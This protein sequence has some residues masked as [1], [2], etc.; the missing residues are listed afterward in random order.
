MTNR[1]DLRQSLKQHGVTDGGSTPTSSIEVLRDYESKQGDSDEIF[2]S[3]SFFILFGL[4]SV[5][6]EIVIRFWQDGSLA[7]MKINAEGEGV[8][9]TRAN[10]TANDLRKWVKN[11]KAKKWLICGLC[12]DEYNRI[13]SC[14]TAKEIWNTLQVDHEGTPQ[15]KRSRGTL[16]YSQYENFTMK[17]RET[18]QDMYTRFTTLTNEL[19]CLGR[20]I[21][22]EDKVEKILTRVL[23]ISW[24]RKITA[25]HES[26]NIAT[27]RLDELIRNLTAYE[28]R[29][30]TMNMDVP[31]KER[32]LALRITE[33]A[34]LEEDEM[35]MIT[36]DFK[37]YLM[38][39]KGSS[40][41]ENYNKARVP[42]KQ[43]NEGCYKC[44]KTDHHIK[45]FPQWKIEW[46]KERSERRNMKKEQVHP[47]K[48]KGST[49]AMVAAWGESSDEESDDEDGDEQALMKIGE[50][51]EESKVSII[52]L[53]DK[54]KF[55]SKE[56][57]SELLLDFIDEF[58]VINKEKEQLSKD[59][60]ILKVKCK[61]LELRV[62]ETVS[63]NT[64]LKNQVHTFEANILE[65]KSE[66]LKLK[67]GTSKKTADCTQLTLEENVGKLKDELYRKDE[68]VR[69]LKEDLGKVKHELDR[70]SKWNRSSDALSWLQEHYSSN[71]RGLG[72]GNQL[73]K[74]YPKS[75]YLTLPENKIC[76]HC[77]KTGHYKSECNAKERASQK[78]KNFVQGKNW[79]PS[80]SEGE[81]P[82]MVHGQWLL[83]ACDRKQGPGKRVNNIYIIDLSTLSE[84]ELTC[85]SVL[86]SD[87]LLWHKRLGHASLSQLN[88]LVSK[89]LVIGLPN[90]KFKE[91]KACE[92]CARGKQEHDDEAIELVKHLNETTAQ[93]EASLEEGTGD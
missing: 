49:K 81:Q 86:D 7:T 27:L 78:N 55:L 63:E 82:N 54:I 42:K 80:S 56:K 36:K 62:S 46:K 60:M 28:L 29:R 2:Y 33:R 58:E 70:T 92:A 47:K 71:R 15:V 30:Q 20:V 89:D 90:I 32:S 52:H 79:L 25:I 22:E 17:E 85:L 8:P 6:L 74:W 61:N 21:L 48:N 72:F 75:K 65:L 9:K 31:K 73:P 45:K 16:L 11:A 18:I 14:T 13:Q 69:V 44:R 77:G 24:E 67:L 41:D 91:E 76:T 35:A 12:P 51:Y 53:K 50:S 93:T 37:K 83:K 10:C 5:R 87:P 3:L 23:P 57:L 66:K 88:K 1:V 38:R 34:D 43:T 64:A 84:N 26:K 19:K 68:Q 59:C 39:G 4:H 40:R